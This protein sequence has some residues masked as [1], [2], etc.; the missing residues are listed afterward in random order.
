MSLFTLLLMELITDFP[1]LLI[2]YTFVCF[3]TYTTFSKLILDNKF[4]LKKNFFFHY[5]KWIKI[6]SVQNQTE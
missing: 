6:R 1:C 2:E 4:S 3:F 5:L